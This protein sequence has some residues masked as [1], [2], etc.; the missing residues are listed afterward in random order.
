[1][2]AF[3]ELIEYMLFGPADQQVDAKFIDLNVV[4]LDEPRLNP[5]HNTFSTNFK[6]FVA[7]NSWT[8]PANNPHFFTYF[9]IGSVLSLPYSNILEKYGIGKFLLKVGEDGVLKFVYYSTTNGFLRLCFRAVSITDEEVD[10]VTDVSNY[11]FTDAE[12]AD[13]IYHFQIYPYSI[14]QLAFDFKI[15]KTF[16]SLQME[17]NFSSL[18]AIVYPEQ[19]VTDLIRV[20]NSVQSTALS[21]GF[22]NILPFNDN[23]GALNSVV[24]FSGFAA[25]I[26]SLNFR[27]T[28]SMKV[29]IGASLEYTMD[30]YFKPEALLDY[31]V[32]LLTPCQIFFV[33]SDQMDQSFLEWNIKKFSRMEYV[34]HIS[35]DR[36]YSIMTVAD[37]NR[38][39]TFDAVRSMVLPLNAPVVHKLLDAANLIDRASLEY[40]AN[41]IRNE[42]NVIIGKLA[43]TN[44]DILFNYLVGQLVTAK[45]RSGSRSYIGTVHSIGDIDVEDIIT[46]IK[47]ENFHMVDELLSYALKDLRP[48]LTNPQMMLA[49]LKGLFSKKYTILHSSSLTNRLILLEDGRSAAISSQMIQEWLFVIHYTETVADHTVP[50][51]IFSPKVSD[52]GHY[53]VQPTMFLDFFVDH[54]MLHGQFIKVSAPLIELHIE[55]NLPSC[56]TKIKRDFSK[57]CAIP[58]EKTADVFDDFQQGKVSSEKMKLAG[59]VIGLYATDVVQIMEK[60]KVLQTLSTLAKYSNHLTLGVIY[61]NMAV[62]LY[63]GNYAGVAFSTVFLATSY[64]VPKAVDTLSKSVTLMSGNSHLSRL[65]RT[66][67]PFLRRFASAF[68]LYTFYSSLKSYLVNKDTISTV[69]LAESGTFLFVDAVAIGLEFA[70]PGVALS[71]FEPAGALIAGFVFVAAES[72]LIHEKLKT[73]DELL[74]LGFGDKFLNGLYTFFTGDVEPILRDMANEKMMNNEMARL[75]SEFMSQNSLVAVYASPSYITLADGIRICDDNVMLFDQKIRTIWADTKPDEDLLPSDKNLLCFT[76]KGSKLDELES[77][78]TFLDKVKDKLDA[79]F[80]PQEKTASATTFTESYFCDDSMALSRKVALRD[81]VAWIDMKN[82]NDIIHGFPHL[83]HIFIIGDGYKTIRANNRENILIFNSNDTKG[84]IELHGKGSLADFSA[85]GI[86]TNDIMNF[87]MQGTNLNVQDSKLNIIRI[88]RIKG[89]KMYPD[90]SFYGGAA[91]EISNFSIEF[92]KCEQKKLDFTEE[93]TKIGVYTNLDNRIKMMESDVESK[94]KV[95]IL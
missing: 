47:D 77:E 55:E 73:Y 33:N 88:S 71:I 4:I 46:Q 58:D 19:L 63:N 22:M 27:T 31:D 93:D 90:K 89:R 75:A 69:S 64:G 39:K 51:I 1:M 38:I 86:N 87:I 72:Y 52:E 94:I 12:L 35:T 10:E 24:E 8:K 85:Y 32:R 40:S 76:S 56:S 62:D 5:E 50:V 68:N 30:I 83:E 17:E 43:S 70:G 78:K 44:E 60:M 23:I 81:S 41:I 80:W 21:S 92:S 84:Y 16:K 15:F 26:L 66:S 7:E 28:Y 91:N 42:I 11:A 13:I 61:K 37:L 6:K 53:S 95:L 9:F 54:L 74:H 29:L 79:F 57:Q 65:F 34:P 82:G 2:A 36:K 18:W 14:E 49:F 3:N 67:R 48:H 25:G 45:P 59:H 20:C